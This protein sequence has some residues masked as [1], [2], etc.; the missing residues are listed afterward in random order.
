MVGAPKQHFTLQASMRH[1]G[2][3]RAP[4]LM[5]STAYRELFNF[6]YH[7]SPASQAISMDM[8]M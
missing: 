1:R 5:T 7:L 3:H 2:C 8:V 4:A 6:Y